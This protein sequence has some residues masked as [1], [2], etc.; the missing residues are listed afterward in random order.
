MKNNPHNDTID[1]IF[2]ID[3][4]Y[5][6][7]IRRAH[8]PFR[9][10]WALPGG[11]LGIGELLEDAVVRE[12]A[13]ETGARI[14]IMA[15][16]IPMPVRLFGQETYLDQI[17]T[18]D[19][20]KDPRGG[21]TTVY[22]V[23]LHGPPEGLKK[24]FRNGSDAD[25]IRIFRLDQLPHELAFDHFSFIEDYFVR[26]KQYK[27]PLPAVDA[28]VEYQGKFVYIERGGTPSGKALP[29]GFAKY[30]KS[31][32]QSVIEEVKEETNLD[33][34]IR[35]MLGVYSDP[36]RDPR[37]HIASTV[38]FG[39]ATGNLRFGDDAKGGG[40][41]TEDHAPQ[42]VFD[43]NRIYEDYLRYKG[44]IEEYER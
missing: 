28:I 42:M 43:H 19:S 36:A 33:L 17:H 5:T 18:Y 23:Q 29:G 35:G 12:V 20:G 22:A 40:L 8:E 44:N 32:E 39:K 2:D 30:G 1:C 26:L 7:L 15:Q 37:K 34:Q 27:N 4:T 11:R 16:R 41:F 13:E 38:F 24:S 25:D 6:V 10:Y 9:G 31:Y 14:E 3:S 21:R